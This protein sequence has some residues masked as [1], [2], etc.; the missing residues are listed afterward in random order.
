M[1]EAVFETVDRRPAYRLVEETLRR[2][3]VE[4][5]LEPGT[6]LP[7]ET[8]LAE[9]LG[10]TRPTVREALRSVESAGLVERGPRRRMMVTAPAMGVVRTAMHEAVVLHGV[11]HRELW[12]V[13]SALGAL[14]AGLAASNAG[15]GLLDQ[16]RANLSAMGERL[17]DPV[18][19]GQLDIEFHELIA[20]GA[21][22]RALLLAREAQA[23]LMRRAYRDDLDKVG[24][25]GGVLDAGDPRIRAHR[26]LLREHEQIVEALAARDA[27]WASTAMSDHFAAFRR[28]CERAGLD[29]DTPVSGTRT[30]DDGDRP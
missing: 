25:D 26:R 28:G 11:T 16:L 15:P 18:A 30:T 13:G 24:L 12:E 4:G 2:R 22:N 23:P 7:P 20:D 14:S 10:V 17:D 9:L 21:G 3:I 5:E 1:P 29:F 8:E 19:V 6:L 27:E